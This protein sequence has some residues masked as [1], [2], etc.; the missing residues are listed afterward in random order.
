MNNIPHT[1]DLL[2]VYSAEQLKEMSDKIK[3][4]MQSYIDIPTVQ[5]PVQTPYLDKF[6]DPNY[7]DKNTVHSYLPVYEKLL[8]PFIKSKAA[9]NMLEIGIQRGGS[10]LGWC[11]AFPNATVIGVDCQKTV[12]INLSN[13]KECITNAYSEEFL[14]LIP[15]NS[16]DFIVEDGSHAYQDILFACRHY[17]SLLKKGGILVIE[18]VPDV[19][20][21]SKMR[22]LVTAQGCITQVVDLRDKKKRWDDVLL[23]IKKT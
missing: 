7:T 18:D 16:Q 3:K 12:T 2:K 11:K 13:F 10:I 6:F 14:E 1:G 17:P 9:F 19:T 15:P 5:Q 20:W 21:L 8:E 4:E 23:L 22:A